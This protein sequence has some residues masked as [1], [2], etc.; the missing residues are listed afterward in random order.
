MSAESPENSD[1]MVGKRVKK[2]REA[3]GFSQQ[4]FAGW[5]NR[6]RSVISKIEIGSRTIRPEEIAAI[7]RRCEVS[8]DWVLGL[9]DGAWPS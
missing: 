5:I 1:K 9:R 3:L 8:S 7:C 6:S 4:E 2:I